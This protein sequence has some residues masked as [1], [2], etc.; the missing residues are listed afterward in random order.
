M[1]LEDQLRIVA[2]LVAIGQQLNELDERDPSGST[3]LLSLIW[4]RSALRM[5]LGLAA[6]LP[7]W[8]HS[9]N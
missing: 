7:L 6:V 2:R 3:K 5:R 1:D 9:I 8:P 4:E